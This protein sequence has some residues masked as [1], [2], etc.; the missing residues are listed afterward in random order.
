LN[1]IAPSTPKPGDS[2]SMTLPAG[3]RRVHAERL[4]DDM[5]AAMAH[6]NAPKNINDAELDTVSRAFFH[7]RN[8]YRDEHVVFTAMRIRPDARGVDQLTLALPSTHGGSSQTRAGDASAGTERHPELTEDVD[9][10]GVQAVSHR[11]LPSEGSEENA[12]PFG[13]LVQLVFVV[14]G[15]ERG[16]IL[17]IVSNVTSD[18]ELLEREAEEIAASVHIT[19]ANETEGHVAL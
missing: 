7:V 15:S 18:E 10:N 14:P 6:G 2:L 9:I 16:A 19:N 11:S 13:S 3:W 5:V 4:L 17:T 8:L 1:M 12:D